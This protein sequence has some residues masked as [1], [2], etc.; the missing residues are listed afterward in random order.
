MTRQV[1]EIASLMDT[2]L[3][4]LPPQNSPSSQLLLFPLRLTNC[5]ICDCRTRRTAGE[6]YTYIDTVFHT[7]LIFS[8]RKWKAGMEGVI[9]QQEPAT[10]VLLFASCIS[11]KLK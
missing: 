10:L 5:M 8:R 1:R 2:G 7:V 9:P 6:T 3:N 11:K 4:A